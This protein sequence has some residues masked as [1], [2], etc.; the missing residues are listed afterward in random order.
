MIL[1]ISERERDLQ[2]MLNAMSQW[3]SNWRLKVNIDKSNIIRFRGKRKPRSNAVF[4]Y[5]DTVLTFTT[6]S[7]LKFSVNPLVEH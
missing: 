6:Q 3:V 2:H 7:V 1:I 4:N 5:A